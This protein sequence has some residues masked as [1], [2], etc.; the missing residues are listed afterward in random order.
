MIVVVTRLHVRWWRFLPSFA[1]H[2]WRIRRQAQLS[3]GFLGGALAGELPRGFWTFSVWTDEPAMRAFQTAAPHVNTMSRL[4]HW[5]DEAS[6]VHWQQDDGHCQRRR[7]RSSGCAMAAICRRWTTP[8]PRTRPA[9][10]RQTWSRNWRGWQCGPGT[11][12][13][14]ERSPAPTIVKCAKAAVGRGQAPRYE[15]VPAAT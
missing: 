13:T 6:Y 1:V 5:C 2:V 15:R 8:A 9:R 3:A 10:R 4:R 11:S 12:D 14:P 7:P